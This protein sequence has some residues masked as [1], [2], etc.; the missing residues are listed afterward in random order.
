MAM[1][2]VACPRCG[3]DWVVRAII[4]PLSEEILLCPECDA[5]W[6][7]DQPI[8]KAAFADY[9]TYVISKGLSQ[10]WALLEQLGPVEVP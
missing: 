10:D 9:G 7:P 1:K 4:K 2:K 5:F 6:R 3:Q 8:S